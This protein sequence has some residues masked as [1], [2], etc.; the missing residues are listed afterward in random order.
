MAKMSATRLC[1]R[2]RCDGEGAA[3]ANCCAGRSKASAS[4]RMSL[5]TVPAAGATFSGPISTVD[6][7]AVSGSEAMHN[8]CP[9]CG[10][11]M[12]NRRENMEGMTAIAASTLDDPERFTPNM[13]VYAS[14]ALSWR[15]H[16]VAI[17]GNAAPR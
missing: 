2:V 8:F 11:H 12:Y 6:I 10:S 16:A 13:T 14:R 5:M 17:R 7:E 15:Q 3:L 9:A 4:G 1:G